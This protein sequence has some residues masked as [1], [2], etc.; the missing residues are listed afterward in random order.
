VRPC[1]QVSLYRPKVVEA[2]LGIGVAALS[3]A[4]SADAITYAVERTL[5]LGELAER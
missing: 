3:L 4:E 2:I 1:A 5:S